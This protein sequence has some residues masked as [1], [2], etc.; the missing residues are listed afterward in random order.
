[1]TRR[2]D[3]AFRDYITDGVLASGDQEVVKSEARAALAYID[4]ERM[5]VGGNYTVATGSQ[6][7]GKTIAITGAAIVLTFAAPSGYHAAHANW[8]VN[9][10]S[11]R[12]SQIVVTGGAS[13]WIYPG[14]AI[15]VFNLNGIWRTNKYRWQPPSSIFNL[16]ADFTN[17]NDTNADGFGT[18]SSAFKTLERALGRLLNDIDFAGVAT[19]VINMADNTDDTQGVHFAPHDFC[20]ANGGAAVKIKGG[21][22]SGINLSA[23]TN[24]ACFETYFGSLLQIE[25]ITLTPNPSNNCFNAL[26]GSKFYLSGVTCKGGG[27]SGIFLAD[28][29][30][31]ELYGACSFQGAFAGSYIVATSNA[32]FAAAG[33]ALDCN[34]DSSFGAGFVLSTAGAVI[35]FNGSAINLHGHA[36]TGSRYSASLNG[37][38][39]SGDG[40][41]T[42]FPGNSGGSASTGGQYV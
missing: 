19:P 20:G 2:S 30:H 6:D 31:I 15:R 1:M 18:G 39:V 38:I 35:G 4:N 36:V 17:G 13:F 40:L 21:T 10:H 9:E 8:I 14:Q 32:T 27:Q 23:S 12:P 41:S 11:T 34:A 28:C 3:L 25:N 26:W 16:Y 37:V 42:Y 22:N 33:Q 24:N 7:F 5:A 29:A